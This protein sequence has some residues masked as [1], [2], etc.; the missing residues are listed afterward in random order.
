VKPKLSLIHG[1]GKLEEMA[2]VPQ[3]RVPARLVRAAAAFTKMVAKGEVTDFLILAVEADGNT[4][5]LG[6]FRGS[7]QHDL[8]AETSRALHGLVTGEFAENDDTPETPGDPFG[9]SL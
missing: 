7:S 3:R 5:T 9:S 2:S 8:I 4:A 6:A 1:N